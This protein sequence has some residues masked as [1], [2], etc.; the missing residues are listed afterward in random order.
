MRNKINKMFV[1]I[2]KTTQDFVLQ[3]KKTFPFAGPDTLLKYYKS[4]LYPGVGDRSQS[5]KVLCKNCGRLV[6]IR[7]WER[8]ASQCKPC[9]YIHSDGVQCN[10]SKFCSTE[11]HLNFLSRKVKFDYCNNLPCFHKSIELNN[12]EL[13]IQYMTPDFSKFLLFTDN[14]KCTVKCLK[15]IISNQNSENKFRVLIKYC[16]CPIQ[17]KVTSCGCFNRFLQN[18]SSISSPNRDKMR[19]DISKLNEH[20]FCLIVLEPRE[21]NIIMNAG[22]LTYRPFLNF[23]GTKNMT[24]IWI[25]LSD[26]EQLARIFFKP[27]TKRDKLLV[28]N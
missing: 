23:R 6:N 26:D 8:H 24:F 22:N 20:Y 10:K 12:I 3:T 17:T 5:Q 7:S 18:I 19:K 4:L 11:T 14:F 16:R 25:V 13:R 2:S 28:L 1:E 15:S 27:K 21:T 9:P